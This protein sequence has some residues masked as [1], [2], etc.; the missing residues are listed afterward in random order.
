MVW[1]TN[2]DRHLDEFVLS[3]IEKG[4]TQLQHETQIFASTPPPSGPQQK[5][6]EAKVQAAKK[7]ESVQAGSPN[8]TAEQIPAHISAYHADSDATQ[9]WRT[10][11]SLHNIQSV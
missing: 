4:E 10:M 7:P 2:F 6:V 3:H 9:V 1:K 5:K 11:H 8:E